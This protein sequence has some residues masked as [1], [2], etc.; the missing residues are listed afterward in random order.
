VLLGSPEPLLHAG[1]PVLRDGRWVGYVRAGA[2]GHTLGASIGLAMIESA[3]DGSDLTAQALAATTF[4]VDIAGVRWP[5][6]ASL[7]PFYDP[8]RLRIKA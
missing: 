6:R 8:D 3:G 7:R 1:E 5:A 4:E 2:F